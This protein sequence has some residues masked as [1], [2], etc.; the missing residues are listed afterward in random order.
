MVIFLSQDYPN[1]VDIYDLH[2]VKPDSQSSSQ[3]NL[4]AANLKTFQ[5]GE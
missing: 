4:A 5:F 3:S 2:S 1:G